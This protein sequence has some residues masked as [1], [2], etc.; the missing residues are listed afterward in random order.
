VL[1]F[2]RR[3]YAKLKVRSQIEAI[4]E[5]RMQGLLAGI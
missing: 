1:S 5:A 3:I 4:H 2:V